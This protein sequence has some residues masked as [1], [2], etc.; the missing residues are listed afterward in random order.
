MRRYVPTLYRYFYWCEFY[1][2]VSS[3][4]LLML[5]A[6]SFCLHLVPEQL[7]PSAERISLCVPDSYLKEK[8]EKMLLVCIKKDCYSLFEQKKKNL[9]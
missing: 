1:F 7:S 9:K 2:N 4:Y 5:S 6:D 8:I 3:P